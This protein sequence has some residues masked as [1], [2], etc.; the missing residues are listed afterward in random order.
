MFVV[1]VIQDILYMKR[2]KSF[3]NVLLFPVMALAVTGYMLPVASL[4]F[5]KA[6]NVCPANVAPVQNYFVFINATPAVAFDTLGVFTVP[7]KFTGEP[8][9]QMRT[10]FKIVSER[11]P[12]ATG[13]IFAGDNMQQAVA[14]RLLQ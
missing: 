3:A 14:I 2:L 7:Q 6:A 4:S 5:Q 11:Y 1:L 12:T 8:R 9:E 10:A 13:L